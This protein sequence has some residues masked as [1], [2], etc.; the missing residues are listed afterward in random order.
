MDRYT[1]VRKIGEGAYGKALLVKGKT[2]GR[3]YVIKEINLSKMDRR[4]RDEARREVRVLSQMKHP[5][6]VAYKDSFEG[7]KLV[8]LGARLVWSNKDN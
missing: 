7:I 6:I 2:D 1:R 3:Q 4:G 8:S 5:N